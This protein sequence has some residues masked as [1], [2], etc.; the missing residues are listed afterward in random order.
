MSAVQV[1]DV[2]GMCHN[3]PVIQEKGEI[4]LTSGTLQPCK[5]IDESPGDS[6]DDSSDGYDD[7]NSCRDED[8]YYA[9]LREMAGSFE[10]TYDED[11]SEEGSETEA[12]DEEKQ[13][14]SRL[15]SSSFLLDARPASLT[16]AGGPNT[17]TYGLEIDG[18]KGSFCAQ[19][20]TASKEF[21]EMGAGKAAG[22][23]K[24]SPG[25]SWSGSRSTGSTSAA[26]PSDSS[27]SELSDASDAEDDRSSVSSDD[28]EDEED[29]SRPLVPTPSH[30]HRPPV[31]DS[32]DVVE[33]VK[34]FASQRPVDVL[35][36]QKQDLLAEITMKQTQVHQL[37]RAS[38]NPHSK[39]EV[40]A[41]Y[42]QICKEIEE[43]VTSLLEAAS[44]F[45][46]NSP[47]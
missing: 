12:E 42:A 25:K 18:S 44:C 32:Y 46:A 7:D 29:L 6:L 30:D 31:V 10:A 20:Q 24:N 21:A 34:H 16:S 33:A 14:S 27:L 9:F 45:K 3:A 22:R 37:R 38:E 26:S 5:Q 47:V 2:Q 1:C 43:E 36:Q 8:D 11:E 35:E 41:H 23:L 13:P 17:R 40:R 39:S 15:R 19:I 28:E 4:Q